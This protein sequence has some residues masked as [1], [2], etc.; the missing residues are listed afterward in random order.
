[1]PEQLILFGSSA[2]AEASVAFA[3]LINYETWQRERKRIVRKLRARIPTATKWEAEDATEAAVELI[4]AKGYAF[5]KLD[6]Y[7]ALLFVSAL[8]YLLNDR[9]KSRRLAP[10]T[11]AIKIEI[12]DETIHILEE[13]DMIDVMLEVLSEDDRELLM[14]RFESGNSIAE[15]ARKRGVTAVLLRARCSRIA[16]ILRRN[17]NKFL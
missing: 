17:R 14:E 8:Y 2:A 12:E 9:K 1:V 7:R 6:D 16:K 15:I 5:P 11:E 4:F 10:I 13:R 3:R